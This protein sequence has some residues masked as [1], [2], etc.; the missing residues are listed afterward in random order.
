VLVALAL[1]LVVVPLPLP[2][3]AVVVVPA[4]LPGLVE[5]PPVTAR[6]SI[7]SSDTTVVQTTGGGMLTTAL[8]GRV[9]HGHGGQQRKEEDGE[10]LHFEVWSWWYLRLG[11][12][13]GW[14]RVKSLVIGW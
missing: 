3:P 1:A 2:L 10:D 12:V 13:V 9:S 11:V 5:Y 7:I 8:D 4:P 14:E 6:V